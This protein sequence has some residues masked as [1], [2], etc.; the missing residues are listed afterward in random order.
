MLR[1]S[2]LR[3]TVLDR[4]LWQI[5]TCDVLRKKVADLP[6][7]G[8][9]RAPQRE[10]PEMHAKNTKEVVQI[11]AFMTWYVLIPGTPVTDYN[12]APFDDGI[13]SGP[14]EEQADVEVL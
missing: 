7:I 13:V 1:E 8:T 12:H 10:K 11:G 14:L 3:T 5:P 9:W 2:Q 6:D 4:N